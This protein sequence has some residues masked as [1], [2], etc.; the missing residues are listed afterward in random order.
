M[1]LDTLSIC[2]FYCKSNTLLTSFVFLLIF[3]NIFELET[4]LDNLNKKYIISYY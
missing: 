2:Y 3:K 4:N 1:R